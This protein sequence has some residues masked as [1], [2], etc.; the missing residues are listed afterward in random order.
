MS[1]TA[2]S[3]TVA[4]VRRHRLASFTVLA[5]AL[6]WLPWPFAAAGVIP[7]G[8]AFFA[9]SPLVAALVVTGI[10]DGRAGYRALLARVLR[11]RV[12]WV[13]YVVA[14]GLPAAL[15]LLTGL[16][17]SWAG[18]P[19]PPLG[20][21]VWTDVLLLLALR[22]VDPTDGALGEEPG[23]RGY[24]LPLLQTRWSPLASAAALGVLTAVWHLP[25]VPLHNLTWVGIPTTFAITFLYVWL[26]DRTRGSV[27]M[28]MLFHA[29]QGAF[30]YG[31]LGYA[32]ADL[33]RAELVYL[34]LVVLAV[35]ATL[36]LDR[37]AW[38]TAAPGAVAAAPRQ[39]AVPA[40]A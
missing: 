5:L 27:L 38:R 17:N 11:W 18:A 15:V 26:T 13:W 37:G 1:A 33:Q 19:A 10:A 23:W 21:I 14:L 40:G 31:R 20:T 35:A 39:P 12:G 6:G 30:T 3:R 9:G 2:P 8:F 32:G 29:S 16:V 24:A 7:P 28:P 4:L 25:L 34:G 36:V 22:L